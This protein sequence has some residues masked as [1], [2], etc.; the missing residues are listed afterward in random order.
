MTITCDDL[1]D[2]VES[3]SALHRFAK[4]L[5]AEDHKFAYLTL[6]ERAREELKKSDLIYAA[7]QLF[8][9]PEPVEELAPH[10]A[11]LR[12]LYPCQGRSPCADRGLRS[13]LRQR[14][15]ASGTFHPLQPMPAEARSFALPPAQA[16]QPLARTR[17][18]RIAYLVALAAATGV[19]NPL[20]PAV[21][22]APEPQ[23]AEA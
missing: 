12:Y 6:P 7:Q 10:I 4:K 14:Q 17:A 3:L 19:T 15:A 21:A 13:D 22:A 16:L 20:Q 5:T 11:L 23:L 9:D 18:E 8:L 1:F 2:V